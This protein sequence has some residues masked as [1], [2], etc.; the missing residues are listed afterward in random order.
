METR[1]PLDSDPGK[2]CNAFM[3]P[4]TL[5][6]VPSKLLKAAFPEV[7]KILLIDSTEVK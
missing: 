4:Y 7:Y 3:V 6:P 5:Q 2:L 1:R